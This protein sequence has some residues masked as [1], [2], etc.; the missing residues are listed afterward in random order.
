LFKV[1]MALH[2]KV[3]PPT[4]KV[5]RPNPKLDVARSPFYLN[6]QARPWIRGASHPRRAS[7]S[8]FGFGGSNFHVTL[9]EY[10]GSGKQARRTNTRPSELVVLGA[11]TPAALAALCRETASESVLPGMMAYLAH[12]T[13]RAYDAA[14]PARLAVVATDEADLA[15]KLSKAAESI[16]KQPEAAF[17]YPTGV[18]Y[19]FGRQP[20]KVAF[21]FPGQ[22]SQY[23]GMGADLAI[24]FSPARRAWDLAADV[25]MAEGVSLQD[26][27]FP[28]PAFDD[29]TRQAHAARLTA[30]EWAQPALGAGSMSLLAMLGAFGLKPDA[31]GGHSFGEVMALHAA[32]A[33]GATDALR[34]ARRRGELMAEAASTVPGAMAA[35]SQE[36]GELQALIAA[37]GLPVVLANHNGPRQSVISGATEAI[38]RAEQVLAARGIAAKRLNVATAYHSPLVSAASPRCADFLAGLEFAPVGIP[39]YSNAEVTPYP[40]DAETLRRRLSEQIAKPV[41]FVEMITAMADSGVETFVEVGPGAVLSG[42]VAEILKGRPHQ[43]VSLDRRGNHGVT[44]LLNGIGQLAV[45][46]CALDFEVLWAE[47]AAPIDPRTVKQPAFTLSI[48]GANYAKPYPPEGGAAALP[49][50]NPPREALVREVEVIREVEVVREVHVPVAAPAASP[51]APTAS[52]DGAQAYAVFQQALSQSHM[53]FQ[54]AMTQSHEQ[55]MTAMAATMG[56]PAP[57]M[58]VAPPT[59]AAQPAFAAPVAPSAPMASVASSITPMPQAPAPAPVPASTPVPAAQPVA[60]QA[61]VAAAAVAP[62][63]DLKA[64]VLDVVAE[65]T[66]YPVEMLGLEMALE[67]DLGIDSIKRVEIL[68]TVQERASGLPTLDPAAMSATRTLGEIVA[69]LDSMTPASAAPPSVSPVGTA[70]PA[71]AVPTAGHDF[72]ALMLTVVSEKTGYPAEMLSAEMALEA[73]LGIDSIKRVE[74]LSAIQERVPTMPA[75]DPAEM[76][77]LRTLGEIAAYLDRLQPAADPATPPTPAAPA[78]AGSDLKGLVLGVVAEKTGYPVEMLG[79][80]MAL[81]ADL[82]IDSIKRVEI[83]STVQDRAVGLPALDPTAMAATRTLGEIVAFLDGLAPTAAPTSA[84]AAPVAAPAPASAPA[85]AGPDFHGLMLAVVSEKTGYPAEMLS[86]EMALEADL[87]IDSIKRV[88]ILSAIQERVPTMPALD[89]AEMAALRT[90]GEI[91]A[92]LGGLGGGS[93][94]ELVSAVPQQA[95]PLGRAVLR[96]LDAPATGHVM[97][98]LPADGAVIVTDDGRGV[99]PALVTRLRASGYDARVSDA[100]PADAAA[101]VF[102]GGLKAWETDEAAIAVNAEAFRAA[103][104]VAGRMAARGGAFVTVQDTGGRFGL[105]GENARAAWAAGLS[106]LAK[107][108]ALEWPSAQVKAIDLAVG[109]DGPDRVA[110]RL[111]N[112]LLAGGPEREVGLP[113]AGG[114]LTVVTEGQAVPA[115]GFTLGSTDVVLASG[116]ARGVTAAT[117]VALAEAFKPKIVLLGRTP[118][119]PED[120]ACQAATDEAGLKHALMTAAIARG[121]KP[122]PAELGRRAT[123]ILANREVNAT[124]DQLRRAGSQAVYLAVDVRDAEALASALAPIR[125]EWGP[126]TAIVHGAG[127]LADKVI[128]DKTPEQFERVFETKVGGL[129]ALLAATSGDPLRAIALFSSVAAR[130]GNPGQCDYAMA[131]EVLN[132]VAQAEARRRGAA[133]VVK[134]LGWGPWDGGMVTPTLKAHFERQGVKL[135]PVA[136]GARMLVD[137]LRAGPGSDVEVVLGGELPEGSGPAPRLTT[138]VSAATH[139]YLADHCVADAPVL[140]AMLALE[141]CF[142]AVSAAR[143]KKPIAEIRD[144]QVLRGITLGGFEGEGDRFVT[145]VQDGPDGTLQL[146]IESPDGT[147]HY[148]A[149]AILG[150]PAA[151]DACPEPTV[152][153]SPWPHAAVYSELLFH[154]PAFRV[155]TAVEGLGADAAAARL[156]GGAAMGWP[157][158]GWQLDVAALDGGLQLAVLWGHQ[159]LGQASLP[160]GVQRFRRHAAGPMDGPIRCVMRGRTPSGHRAVTD[161]W[162]LG[163]DGRVLAELSGVE[164]VARPDARP[165]A[166]RREA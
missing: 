101:V 129:R 141:W 79:L 13:Q 80:D 56:A 121:E 33:V 6:T 147:R 166:A 51:V 84:P 65:K 23:V 160:M 62:R 76:A 19:A 47:L 139:P 48:T 85:A 134:S 61:P 98:P 94:V 14:L 164:T 153:P 117:L 144:L 18:H 93:P 9:E 4:I 135:L 29:E 104:A 71:V 102:M 108:A 157:D 35:V 42:L 39:V 53:A 83:L 87:G 123:Q 154:G 52:A 22:G 103:K 133:C 146:T 57:A 115:G 78:S 63:Q 99:A 136:D 27:V 86:A 2:H 28:R 43:A 12:R 32:G 126:V 16:E 128:A 54:S 151:P 127:V 111:A 91:A 45:A 163:P 106:G 109:T 119:T 89:P 26:V 149:T 36:A 58:P 143:P 38:A 107:T 148:R 68:S 5:D 131:N 137:E 46:G 10:A 92:Y 21:L 113:A 74:I 145:V 49:K 41:R 122:Q 3:L 64:L 31:L 105:G 118:L 110:E 142:R 124:I 165:V 90:L 138:H 24:A 82:G 81:E 59:Y 100:V 40:A 96:L 55:F 150:Q 1:V 158:E 152:G 73:D 25:P 161:L 60:V 155:V 70:P 75:L 20:G 30:T 11:A 97:L 44:S 120:P 34:I 7:M 140:P 95:A 72:Q 37:E 17:S 66:G 8:S 162:F 159:V 15:S 125:A 130:M 116:G 88:E 50:P 112:E 156:V 69:F 77:A 132:K 114:R 67:A